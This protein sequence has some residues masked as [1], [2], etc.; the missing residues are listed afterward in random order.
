[1][2]VEQGQ[3]GK[4]FVEKDILYEED[5]TALLWGKTEAANL[6]CAMFNAL[7][8]CD[9]AALGELEAAAAELIDL[10]E[11]VRVGEYTP[12]AFTT[13][14]ARAALAAFRGGKA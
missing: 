2:T 3:F 6:A 4:C 13:Q 11:A 5:G 10:M 14:P 8:G 9:P 12:D 7:A 1:M